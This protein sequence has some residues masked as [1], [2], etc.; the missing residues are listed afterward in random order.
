LLAQA[1]AFILPS[2]NEGLPMAL[3][4]AMSWRLPAI[5]TPVGG[6]PEI[7]THQKTG[8]LIEPGDI[9]ALAASIKTLIDDESLRLTLGDEAYQ[10]ASKLDINNYSR[11]ILNMYYSTINKHLA[12]RLRPK[13]NQL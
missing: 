3:L 4:E 1:D 2:Y 7:I 10:Q 13:K 6:I 9:S 8:L 5:T 12:D 11:D